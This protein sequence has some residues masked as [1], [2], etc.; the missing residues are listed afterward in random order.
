VRSICRRLSLLVLVLAACSSAVQARRDVQT[1]SQTAQA[2]LTSFTAWSEAHQVPLTPPQREAFRKHRDAQAA[3]AI[4]TMR[5]C[6]REVDQ[7]LGRSRSEDV[8]LAIQA[9]A[10]GQA[11]HVA[12]AAF[13]QREAGGADGGVAPSDGGHP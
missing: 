5:A 3:P 12:L 13:M 9:Q 10:C 8:E 11:F 2:E 1:A 6:F 7:H 4:A